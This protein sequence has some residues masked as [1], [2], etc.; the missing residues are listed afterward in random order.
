MSDN[1]NEPGYSGNRFLQDMAREQQYML[2]YRDGRILKDIAVLTPDGPAAAMP[3]GKV[4][5]LDD[6]IT[7]RSFDGKVIA[8][9]LAHEFTVGDDGKPAN[10]KQA[11]AEYEVEC[12]KNGDRLDVHYVMSGGSAECLCE[13]ELDVPGLWEMKFS[14]PMAEAGAREEN[15]KLVFDGG[16]AKAFNPPAR[17]SVFNIETVKPVQVGSPLKF[18]TGTPA[19]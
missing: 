4:F 9:A 6:E 3:A 12:T 13:M 19:A 11:T 10:V 17:Y 5:A 1:D 16:L 15:G 7:F 14:R 2:T 8:Q 18:R